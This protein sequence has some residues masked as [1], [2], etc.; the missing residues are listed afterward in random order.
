MVSRGDKGRTGR[1]SRRKLDQDEA[2]LWREVTGDI[3]PLN[4]IRDPVE[5]DPPDQSVSSPNGKKRKVARVAAPGPVIQPP[6]P[7]LR[8]MPELAPGQA[9]GLDRRAAMRLRRGQ[10]RPEA[11]LDLHGHTQAEAHAALNDFILG[12]K[13]SERR[14]V[15]VITG[16]GSARGSD[17]VLRRMV[18]RW[19]NQP[20]LRAHVLAFEPA[21]PR[22][23]GDGAFYMLLRRRRPAG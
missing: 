1:L 8:P 3:D 17:G 20:N 16:K 9:A 10:M 14:C 13:G 4:I 18:P 5:R 12:S 15:L 23:G 11:R 7:R 2:A 6:A 19:I 22:D 21:Q